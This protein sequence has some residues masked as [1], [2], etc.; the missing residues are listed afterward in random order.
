MDG[1]EAASGT[2]ATRALDGK[3]QADSHEKMRVY[4]FSLESDGAQ[5]LGGCIASRLIPLIGFSDLGLPALR[6]ARFFRSGHGAIGLEPSRAPHARARDSSV[7]QRRLSE[8]LRPIAGHQTVR[9]RS[10][11][12]GKV[13]VFAD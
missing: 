10:I 1:R 7:G 13:Q 5:P 12:S 3:R 9:R 2:S 4:P 11:Y 8:L 6:Y